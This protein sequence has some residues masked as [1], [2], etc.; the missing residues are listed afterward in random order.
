MAVVRS[1][2]VVPRM[3]RVFSEDATIALIGEVLDGEDGVL[4]ALAMAPEEYQ[5][6]LVSMY[7]YYA[8]QLKTG[9]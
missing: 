2:G 9:G 3:Q 6:E 4:E 5:I 7:G 8:G 1:L